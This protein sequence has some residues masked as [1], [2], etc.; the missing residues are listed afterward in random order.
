MYSFQD[1]GQI[2]NSKYEQFNYPDKPELLYEPIRY[3]MSMGGKKIRPLL[4]LASYNL[5]NDDVEYAFEAALSVEVF[6]NFSLL[7][8]DIMD[9]ADIRR[10]QATTH[11]NFDTNA[12][13]LS[14]DAM[15]IIAYQLLEKYNNQLGQLYRLFSKTAIEVCEGQR[16]DMDFETQADVAIDDYINMIRLKTSVLIA[17]ALK[18]GAL[19]ADA[20]QSDCEHLYEFGLNMGI[21]FQVQD[22]LLDTFGDQTLVGKKIGGDILQRKKTYLYLKSLDLLSQKEAQDLRALYAGDDY[23]DTMIEKV[24]SLFKKAHVDVHAEELKLVYQQLAFSHLAA[25]NV[26]DEKKRILYEFAEELLNRKL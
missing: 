6:H 4:T 20:D 8:D 12:A 15:L 7:H 5:F 23:D 14:G 18:L 26:S 17:C 21:A 1:L 25:I 24:K 22:D 3:I 9:D 13:I 11:V 10:G 2:Y 19:I 16:Y